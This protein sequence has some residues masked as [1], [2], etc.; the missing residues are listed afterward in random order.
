MPLIVLNVD[1]QRAVNLANLFVF[2]LSDRI[3]TILE[4]G[5]NGATN[6]EEVK[7]SD[8]TKNGT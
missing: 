1:L 5:D 4:T 7:L 2:F 6:V 3:F 8:L